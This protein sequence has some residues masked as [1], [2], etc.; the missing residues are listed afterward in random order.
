MV[1]PN[2]GLASGV[3]TPEFQVFAARL[4]PC[5]DNNGKVAGRLFGS[6]LLKNRRQSGVD[7]PHSKDA[8]AG[9]TKPQGLL[10]ETNF[11][12]ARRKD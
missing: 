11:F 12:S 3:K 7:P 5:P 4:K 6:G 10:K 2:I 1:S 9:D 8:K